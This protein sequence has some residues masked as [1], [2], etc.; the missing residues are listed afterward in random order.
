[1]QNKILCNHY[2]RR[3]RVR[4]TLRGMSPLE[5]GLTSAGIALLCLGGVID[6]YLLGSW[7]WTASG[8]SGRKDPGW[9]QG[10]ELGGVRKRN[11]SPVAGS[12][13]DTNAGDMAIN[14]TEKAGGSNADKTR[15]RGIQGHNSGLELEH[16]GETGVPAGLGLRIDTTA[17]VVDQV[18]AYWKHMME[19]S[20][21]TSCCEYS[22]P[23]LTILL[24]LLLFFSLSSSSSSFR[25]P[26]VSPWA[27]AR[28]TGMLA[29]LYLPLSAH[30]SIDASM[31]NK[32]QM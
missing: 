1:M 9:A 28:R 29:C 14:I 10:K 12:Q 31:R 3:V 27:L 23:S 30:R 24:L 32:I 5:N 15:D 18:P 2:E 25:S 6:L 21:P 26:F 4:T 11:N 13:T 16:A 7:I 20:T 8:S 19:I 17:V 22:S